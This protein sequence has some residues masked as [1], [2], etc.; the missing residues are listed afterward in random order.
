M[1]GSVVIY[2]NAATRNLAAELAVKDRRSLVAKARVSVGLSTHQASEY[3][4]RDIF[5]RST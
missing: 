1:P 3:Y 2:V 4:R 5:R